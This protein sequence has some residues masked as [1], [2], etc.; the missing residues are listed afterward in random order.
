MRRIYDLLLIALFLFLCA[1][2]NAQTAED[3]CKGD[4]V[5]RFYRLAL[6]VTHT[7]F[8]EDFNE[9]TDK[10]KEF[11]QDAEDFMNRLYIPLGFCFDV[12]EDESLVMSSYNLI[13]EKSTNSLSHGTELLNTIIGDDNYDVGL[14]IAL[15]L[16]WDNKGVSF[17]G[18]AYDPGKKAGGYAIK[19]LISVAHEV[20]HLFGAIH[21]HDDGNHI[22]AGLGQSVMGY[23]G[24]CDFFALSSI[25]QIYKW[26]DEK[27]RAY[28]A[29]RARTQLVGEDYGG[30]YVYGVKVDNSA[31]VIDE[32][33]MKRVYDVP[34]GGCFGIPVYA[35]DADGDMLMYAVQPSDDGTPFCAYAPSTE[36][37]VNFSPQFILFPN[38]DYFY[39]VD[40]TD[41]KSLNPGI[42]N[43]WVGVNDLPSD[44]ELTLE[45]MEAAPFYSRYSIFKC[46]VRVVGGVGFEVSLQPDV[47][48]YAAGDEVLVTWGVNREVFNDNTKVRI[49]LSDDYGKSFKYILAENVPVCDGCCSVRLP[50][51]AIGKVLV[52]FGSEARLLSG[53]IIRVEEVGGVAYALSSMSPTDATW[54]NCVGGFIVNGDE[55]SV[56]VTDAVPLAPADVFDVAGRIIKRGVYDIYNEELDCGV[57]VFRGKKVVISSSF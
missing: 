28:Y 49:T 45:A 54:K 44:A 15:P 43:F 47:D 7:S 17:I 41:M 55:T 33:L 5:L 16:N 40:G 23:G 14:W 39:I 50:N 13:D 2:T 21:P 35:T 56:N 11:W 38:D 6:P 37:V 3:L 4:G 12:I 19:E 10:V 52:N 48:E 1:E 34:R 51:V 57:Y 27:N 9:E 24:P 20:G 18:G 31:P 42:Y 26:N 32:R 29:D 36:N 22:E 46:A 25:Q 8:I 53:G 30:N